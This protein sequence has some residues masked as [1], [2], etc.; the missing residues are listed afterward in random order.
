MNDAYA[1]IDVAF[2][3]GKRL[4]VVVCCRQGS[5]L[6]PLPLRAAKAKPPQGAGNAK[7]L[8]LSVVEKFASASATY[9][10]AVQSE[11][12]V[13]IRRVAIDAPS[14]PRPLGAPRRRAEAELDRRRISCI[15][16]PDVE[17]FDAICANARIHLEQRRQESRLP[18]ANQLWMLVGFALFHALRRD[19]ECLE[20]FPQAIAVVLEANRTHKSKSEGLLAQL[21]SAAGHTGWPVTP[22]MASLS[23]IGYGSMHDRLD[24]YLSS[25]VASLDES[26][27]EPLGEPPNDVIWI[28]KLRPPASQS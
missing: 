21:T 13:Q 23:A 1:G 18:G 4:P 17:K 11:F 10:R 5:R 19:W 2:A 3:K 25:W 27:R 8:D 22:S 24:A 20:V 6:E 14:D 26:N 15:T 28:P 9:L 7:I 12:G 16:T